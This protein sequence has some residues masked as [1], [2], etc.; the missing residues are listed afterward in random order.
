VL[1]AG[2]FPGIEVTEAGLREGV[3]YERHLGTDP[4]LFDDV[5]TASVTN[6]AAQYG[7]DEAHTH[8][9]AHLAL[10]MFD[11]LADADLHPGD[12]EERRLVWAAALLHDIGMAVDYD[13]HHHHSRYLVLNG[14]LPGWSPRELVIIAEIVRYHRKGTPAFGDDL[15]PWTAKGDRAILERGAALLRLA[16]GLERSRDQLVRDVRVRA[17]DTGAVC[18]ELE[19]SGDTRV[20]RWAV[21]REAELF[22]RAFGRPLQITEAASAR[23]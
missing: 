19:A 12:E 1:E 8:H 6:L 21:E 7:A 18:L 22:E 2:D 13:D 15:A 11:E 5:R 16:E 17:S 3:F 14:A 23:T 20:A 4:P 9:V 10:T